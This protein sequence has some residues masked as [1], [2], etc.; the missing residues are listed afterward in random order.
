MD[1]CFAFSLTE[2]RVLDPSRYPSRTFRELSNFDRFVTTAFRW[3]HVK[4]R[5]HQ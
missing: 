4:P 3:K 5:V 1:S 2:F